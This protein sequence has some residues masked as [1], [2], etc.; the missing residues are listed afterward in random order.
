MT[1]GTVLYTHPKYQRFL[2]PVLDGF[3]DP[4]TGELF[5]VVR[6]IPRFCPVDNYSQS[7]GFQWNHF[8]RT[9]LDVHSGASTSQQRFYAS[10]G[11]DP[12][13]LHRCSV[14]EVGSVQVVSVRYFFVQLLVSFIVSTIRTPLMPTCVKPCL[15]ST[16]KV[17]T[18]IYL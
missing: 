11:W 15:C 3:K 13:Q 14:L 8:D 18:S 2:V 6:G 9:Q 10:T 7:F 1:S 16:P 4:D 5:P 12:L 17:S